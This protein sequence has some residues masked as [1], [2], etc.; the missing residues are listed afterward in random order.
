MKTIE[1]LLIT[2]IESAL[3]TLAA[4]YEKD[5]VLTNDVKFQSKTITI[6]TVQGV[7]RTGQGTR[8]PI[9]NFDAIQTPIMLTFQVESNFLQQ[10]LGIVNVY[11]AATNGVVASA[12]DSTT[13]TTY[14]YKLFWN[15]PIASGAPYSVDFKSTQDGIARESHNVVLVVLTG[16]VLSSSAHS[17]DDRTTYIEIPIAT[18]VHEWQA[19]NE[20]YW[21][22]QAAAN[23]GTS[24][25]E[26]GLVGADPEE[27]PA[28]YALTFAMRVLNEN[29]VYDY[30]KV[31]TSS[32]I[33]VPTYVELVG[34]TSFAE[35][36]QPILAADQPASALASLLY[37]EGYAT[38][39]AITF[40]WIKG[41]ILHDFFATLLHSAVTST[42]ADKN[43]RFVI[44]SLSITDNTTCKIANLRLSGAPNFEQFSLTLRRV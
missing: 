42:T 4:S 27:D 43:V 12:T 10:F 38:T 36:F 22:A 14:S 2:T 5:V 44:T 1:Q 17:L 35:D 34:I 39:Y 28:D 18:P 16:A 23:R 15:T 37:F 32:S 13:S 25:F 20:T 8:S 11:C 26:G 21:N 7:M 3:D 40:P 19:S 41:N 33:D 31:G 29:L 24:V 9:P 6:D 30:F